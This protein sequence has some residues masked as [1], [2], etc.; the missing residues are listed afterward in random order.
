MTRKVFR[1]VCFAATLLGS[2]RYMASRPNPAGSA[3]PSAYPPITLTFPLGDTL[4]SATLGYSRR[5]GELDG[6]MNAFSLSKTRY[7]DAEVENLVQ[8]QTDLRSV[9]SKEKVG[10][11]ISQFLT[12]ALIDVGTDS[13]S[14]RS[15]SGAILSGFLAEAG[16]NG[17]AAY[18]DTKRGELDRELIE[19]LQKHL[20]EIPRSGDLT[21][22]DVRKY[23]L[24]H[25]EFLL[26]SDVLS[27]LKATGASPDE[28]QAVLA[29]QVDRLARIVTKPVSGD[30]SHP[31]R[32]PVS[33]PQN[34][35]RQ[36]PLSEGGKNAEFL[37]FEQRIGKSLDGLK[38]GQEKLTFAVSAINTTVL[39]DSSRINEMYQILYSQLPASRQRKLMEDSLA[40]RKPTS[41]EQEVLDGLQGRELFEENIPSLVNNLKDLGTIAANAGLPAEYQQA[42][43]RLQK[44]GDTVDSI[45]KAALGN[46]PI[47]VFAGLTTLMAGNSPDV[48]AQR[49][50]YIAEQLG[51]IR[52]NQVAMM[53]M[54]ANLGS[55]LAGITEAIEKVDVHLGRVALTSREDTE[56]TY[57]F[58]DCAF[59]D[60]TRGLRGSAY[61]SS[62]G[63]FKNFGARKAHYVHYE[64]SYDSCLTGLKRAFVPSQGADLSQLFQQDWETDR[65]GKPISFE[66]SSRYAHV[67]DLIESYSPVFHDQNAGNHDEI[68][69]RLFV[70]SLEPT[71]LNNIAA[72]NVQLGAGQPYTPL[73][74]ETDTSSF[75]PE[76]KRHY[77]SV[78]AVNRYVR[79]LLEYYPYFI[80]VGQ[81]NGIRDPK[82]LLQ[83]LN[84]S[85]EQENR[86]MTSGMLASALR[87]VNTAIAQQELLDSSLTL[88]AIN[89]SF[90][91]WKYR[92]GNGCEPG[93]P[94]VMSDQGR[95]A[96]SA[97]R[98]AFIED[99]NETL[100]LLARRKALRDNWARATVLDALHNDTYRK[101]R[102]A[103]LRA[104]PTVTS[105]Q[106]AGQ[107][108]DQK[109]DLEFPR[110]N[111]T[112]IGQCS[113]VISN[114]L[115]PNRLKDVQSSLKEETLAIRYGQDEQSSVTVD[116]PDGLELDGDAPSVPEYGP[117]MFLLRLLRRQLI[118]SLMQ[119]HGFDNLSPAQRRLAA[120]LVVQSH[121]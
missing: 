51:E 27:K 37:L 85:S 9:L 43:A 76:A 111:P 56:T 22:G 80:F 29:D 98:A 74:P 121:N 46:N 62:D 87:L 23:F 8:S 6:L 16:K 73:H 53:K 113:A 96:L 108:V 66:W 54:L 55:A 105:A 44:I 40:G 10:I 31:E 72:L 97:V 20:S 90:L 106:A 2:S 102:E 95:A 107:V 5:P 116:L 71:S 79:Y 68:F 100:M 4:S 35:M 81:S 70:L 47:G 18:Y 19:N 41:A 114:L 104:F 109:F 11:N 110:R 69:N 88:L 63:S 101:W 58:K 84:Y 57:G 120:Y 60:G 42:I 59:L 28:I 34:Q 83:Q 30:T 86:A 14:Q 21:V 77:L 112:A 32:Q 50:G 3:E 17:L 91:S 12:D 82:V 33:I 94:Q 36:Q 64:K 119:L 48:E 26:G 45:G 118:G 99:N 117:E 89:E 103:Y 24:E 49:F 52:K 25:G 1:I 61:T 92:A 13:V 15:T 38:E 65:S 67:L 93:M 7:S 75:L 78:L 39:A 115:F